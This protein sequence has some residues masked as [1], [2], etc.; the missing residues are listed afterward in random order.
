M[1]ILYLSL[2]FGV[3]TFLTSCKK[4]NP[5]SNAPYKIA[6]PSATDGTIY[7]LDLNESVVNWSGSMPGGKHTGIIKLKEGF[8]TIKD[9]IIT[10][11]RFF[12][13]MNTITVT[14]LK[15]ED[16][17]ADLENHLKGIGVKKQKDHFFNV[18]KY[19]TSDFKITKIEKSESNFLIYGNLSIKGITKAVN[20]PATIT[21]TDK[22]VII[23]SDTLALNRTYFNVKYASKTLFGDLK[24][25]FINDA[26][27]IQVKVKAAR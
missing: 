10:S 17:K 4:E 18:T 13:D 1:K 3:V 9:T 25:K 22:E 20:F 14:D 16:G 11:G 2:V 7:T 27:E 26:I 8:V 15:P 24:D 5:E 12:M 6:K 21:L 23:I 19:P